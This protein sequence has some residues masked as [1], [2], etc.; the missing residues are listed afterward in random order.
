M[1]GL[2][3]AGQG[4]R[5]FCG[6]LAG[7]KWAYNILPSIAVPPRLPPL[8]QPK[9]CRATPRCPFTQAQLSFLPFVDILPPIPHGIVGEV[10]EGVVAY[11]LVPVEIIP[12]KVLDLV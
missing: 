12:A 10:D 11:H 3:Y 1:R 9:I 2:R 5:L 7:G 4:Y 8:Q 6:P